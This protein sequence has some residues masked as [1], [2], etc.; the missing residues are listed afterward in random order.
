MTS[1]PSRSDQKRASILKAA[2]DE[3]QRLGFERAG[4]D[5]IA[6]AAKVSKRTVYNHFQ[7]KEL[8]FE[9]II[10][11]LFEELAELGVPSYSPDEPLA[12]QLAAIGMA[13]GRMLGGTDYMNLSRIAIS[14]FLLE[15]G[16]AEKSMSRQASL[17]YGLTEWIQAAVDDGRLTVEDV[18]F[19]TTQF[20]SL[21]KAFAFWPQLIAQHPKPSK[22]AL[23]S[24]VDRTVAMFLDHYAKKP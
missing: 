13:Y 5:G 6:E 4:M 16:L 10:D 1:S 20:S 23:A 18:D 21:L 24:L 9:A 19:A 17:S 2:A 11:K 15:P 12:E 3:F 22:K 7:S 14:R 8:L